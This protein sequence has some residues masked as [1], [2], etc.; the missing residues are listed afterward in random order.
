MKRTSVLPLLPL[1]LLVVAI[2]IALATPPATPSQNDDIFGAKSCGFFPPATACPGGCYATS[3]NENQGLVHCRVVTRLGFYSPENETMVRPCDAGYFSDEPR[4]AA[5]KPC[6]V[7]TYNR[8]MGRTDCLLCP[9]GFFQDQMGQAQCSACSKKYYD[10][11][12][13]NAKVDENGNSICKLVASQT[14]TAP[15]TGRASTN[16]GTGYDENNAPTTTQPNGI[17]GGGGGG[18]REGEEGLSVLL[19]MVAAAIGLL[20]GTVLSALAFSK[21]R[22]ATNGSASP[23]NEDSFDPNKSQLETEPFDEH[24]E[25]AIDGHP[26]LGIGPRPRQANMANHDYA[27][28]VGAQPP[29]APRVPGPNPQRNV[30]FLSPP[31]AHHRNNNGGADPVVPEPPS[32]A[33]VT[34]YYHDEGLGRHQHQ[35]ERKSPEKSFEDFDVFYDDPDVVNGFP[36]ITPPRNV[37]NNKLAAMNDVGRAELLA[38]SDEEYEGASEAATA[39]RGQNAALSVSFALDGEEDGG[40]IGNYEGYSPMSGSSQLGDL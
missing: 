8:A 30:A 10:G 9:S 35:G 36:G 18:G 4:A 3:R 32:P 38:P 2:G 22:K 25:A 17:R 6:G 39:G 11:V 13:A 19:V 1:W 5:C 31:P 28:E 14:T 7:G 24:R 40:S 15:G 33:V 21:R 12:G 34:P 16:T 29:E 27:N 20:F 23:T 26:N 37:G